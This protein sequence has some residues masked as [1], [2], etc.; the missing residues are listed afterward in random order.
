MGSPRYIKIHNEIKQMIE[1]GKW[2]VGDR[3]PS[4]RVLALEFDVSRMTLRQAVQ[5]WLTKEFWNGTWAL[6]LT[7]AANGCKKK[8]L[9][10][11]QA[12]R[13]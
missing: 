5:P 11:L 3:I 13:S 6:A 9:R 8:R 7:S 2:R 4:E 12:L 1:A 10:G